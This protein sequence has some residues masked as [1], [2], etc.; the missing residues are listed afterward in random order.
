MFFAQVKKTIIKKPDGDVKF[1]CASLKNRDYEY[2][3]VE[4]DMNSAI[5]M[6][7]ACP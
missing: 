1:L 2:L 6:S 7:I 3:S 4:T 5:S